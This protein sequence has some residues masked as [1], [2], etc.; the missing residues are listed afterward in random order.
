ML[1]PVVV[2]VFLLSDFK[3]RDVLSR[4]AL[5]K[6]TLAGTSAVELD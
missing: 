3:I 4:A 2:S 6:L 5:S 1:P